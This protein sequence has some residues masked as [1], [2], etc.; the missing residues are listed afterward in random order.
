MFLGCATICR[1]C[2]VR[3]DA[4]VHT[5]TTT[6][7]IIVSFFCI[8]V[9]FTHSSVDSRRLHYRFTG[10]VYISNACSC[11]RLCWLSSDVCAFW[12]IPCDSHAHTRAGHPVMAM[13]CC[14]QNYPVDPPTKLLNISFVNVN[15]EEEPDD[16][17]NELYFLVCAVSTSQVK[18][19]RQAKQSRTRM[20]VR[21]VQMVRR[22]NESLSKRWWRNVLCDKSNIICPVN[23]Q[24]KL[25]TTSWRQR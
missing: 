7:T 14:R 2:L 9:Q 3:C 25:H 11:A 12:C 4:N 5:P 8:D 16:D 13:R 18:V 24:Q 6:I 23:G 20:S 15:E 19:E 10:K 1:C 21:F 17:V 22:T